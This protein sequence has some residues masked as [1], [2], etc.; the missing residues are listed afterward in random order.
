[1]K[2]PHKTYKLNVTCESLLPYFMLIMFDGLGES[3]HPTW[4]CT[5]RVVIYSFS[6]FSCLFIADSRSSVKLLEEDLRCLRVKRDEI[7]K[8][9]SNSRY[10]SK[11][12]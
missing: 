1:M 10:W 4:F 2:K 11:S 5:M 7:I 8:R 3:P 12:M 9:M 6:F